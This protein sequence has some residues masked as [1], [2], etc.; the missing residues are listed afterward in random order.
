MQNTKQKKIKCR[1][2]SGVEEHLREMDGVEV[3]VGLHATLLTIESDAAEPWSRWRK[4]ILGVYLVVDCLS[5][6]EDCLD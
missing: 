4:W 2:K 6:W 1:F 5:D 3:M